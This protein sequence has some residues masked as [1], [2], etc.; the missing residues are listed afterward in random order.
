MIADRALWRT[1]EGQLVE[2][3][4][5]SGA[6][7]IQAEGLEIRPK[8]VERFGLVEK[9]GKVSQKKDF[10]V[11]QPVPSTAADPEPEP[12]AEETE[13]NDNKVLGA[14]EP[15]KTL[16]PPVETDKDSKVLTS[17]GATGKAETVK[18]KAKEG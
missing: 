5:P 15:A 2:D 10:T 9:D 14:P 3:D 13:K 12:G 6:F 7:L 18:G 16:E 17:A 8:D 11:S 4:D 1:A